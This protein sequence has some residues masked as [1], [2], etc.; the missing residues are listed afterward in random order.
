MSGAAIEAQ[1]PGQ[2]AECGAD[3]ETGDQIV[4]EHGYRTH[5]A[6]TKEEP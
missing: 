1:H 6:C 2:C 3:I 4:A 5:V